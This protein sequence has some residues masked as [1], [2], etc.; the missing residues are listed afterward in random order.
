MTQSDSVD[1]ARGSVG[2]GG[3]GGQR[4]R[5]RRCLPLPLALQGSEAFLPL[6]RVVTQ[7]KTKPS[8]S[9]STQSGQCSREWLLM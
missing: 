8:L 7:S 9:S 3:E 4:R 6:E 5:S 2:W 1:S